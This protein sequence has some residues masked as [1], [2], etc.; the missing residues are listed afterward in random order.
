MAETPSAAARR[1][2]L[3][4]HRERPEHRAQVIRSMMAADQVP[5]AA[6][7]NQAQ[8]RTGWGA[9]FGGNVRT[10]ELRPSGL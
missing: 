6:S 1:H 10:F 4:R 7:L 5:A 8:Q 9:C 3:I 2:G